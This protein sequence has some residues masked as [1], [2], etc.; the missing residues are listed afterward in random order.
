MNE[1]G[2][3]ARS[4]ILIVDDDPSFIADV[5]GLLSSRYEIHAA[6]DRRSTLAATQNVAFAAVLLDLDL[7]HGDDGLRLLPE[8]HRLEPGLPVIIVTQDERAVSALAALRGG[9]ADYIGKNVEKHDLEVRLNN[10]IETQTLR[11]Q[12]QALRGEIDA[13][14]GEMIGESAPMRRLW[15]EI[16]RAAQS[17]KLVRPAKPV[18]ISG[19]TGT[20]KELVAR[21]LHRLACPNAPFV[22]LN[23]GMYQGEIFASELFGSVVGGFT[24]AVN[25]PGAC[26]FV[27]DGIL[28]LDE[29]AETP[30]AQQVS[31]LRLIDPGEFSR[32]GEPS[33]ARPFRGRVV[34]ATNRNPEEA[35]ASGLL[36]KDLFFRLKT[37]EL[38]VAPLRERV[39][40]VPLLIEHFTRR[41][42]RELNVDPPF[43]T[44]EEMARLCAHTWPGNVRELQST[45]ENYVA[46]GRL[47]LPDAQDRGG[48]G[49][50]TEELLAMPREEAKEEL[51]LRFDRFYVL[52]KLAAN[53]GDIGKTAEQIGMSRE[54]LK[55]LLA[56]IGVESGE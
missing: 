46:S 47:K 53:H 15:E 9:A 19:E 22:A 50:L 6:T 20:G 3:Q 27:G 49:L 32:I 14:K 7:G 34:A 51:M 26:E 43:Y 23:C 54:G 55:K 12:Y 29:V 45:V 24:S 25:R 35:V 38:Q 30:P 37:Y 11:W 10:A 21:A 44:Q 33:K 28:F 17:G 48:A 4:R 13:L 42:A 16:R 41:F 8:I 40:D 2:V 36:R 52:P 31:L 18:L 5:E 1:T 56:R 39:D